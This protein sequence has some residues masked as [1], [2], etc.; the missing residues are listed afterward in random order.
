MGHRGG[1]RGARALARA[2]VHTPGV[3]LL[4]EPWTGLDAASVER[5]EAVI[6]EEVQRGSLVIAVTH[7]ADTAAR[8][9][10]RRVRIEHGRVV[11]S[12]SPTA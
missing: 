11:P 9:G 8:M 5:L 7:G 2:L 4:D 6:R 12:E 3:L 10:A 1:G